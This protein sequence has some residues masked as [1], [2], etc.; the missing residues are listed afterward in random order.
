MYTSGRGCVAARGGTG[1]GTGGADEEEDGCMVELESLE[2]EDLEK[3]DQTYKIVMEML[4]KKFINV[5]M[6]KNPYH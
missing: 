1:D 4:L 5:L 2:E 6:G 3:N